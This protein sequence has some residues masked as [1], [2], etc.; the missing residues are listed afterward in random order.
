M[1]VKIGK[2][3][4]LN[5]LKSNLLL[6]KKKYFATAHPPARIPWDASCAE[7]ML[8]RSTAPVAVI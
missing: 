3:L 7:L 8:C 5:G 4:Y 2:V 1:D 6:P